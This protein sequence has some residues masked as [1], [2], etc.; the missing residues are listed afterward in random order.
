MQM[1]NPLLMISLALIS[2]AG[3]AQ[4]P[5]AIDFSPIDR[6]T[7][8]V[9]L[10]PI[11]K[12]SNYFFRMPERLTYF[13]S[14]D[15][16]T[17]EVFDPISLPIRARWH[18]AK[19]DYQFELQASGIDDIKA[20]EVR[21]VRTTVY[22]QNGVPRDKKGF[23]QD[24]TCTFYCYLLLVDKRDGKDEPLE[25]IMLSPA[26]QRETFTVHGDFLA[27]DNRASYLKPEMPFATQK[28]LADFI[29]LSKATIY[30]KAEQI[31]AARV[32]GR[33][34]LPLGVLYS[35]YK[36]DRFSYG[37]GFVKTKKRSNNYDDLDAL[38]PLYK[39]ALDSFTTLHFAAAKT[40]ADTLVGRY[41]TLLSS[42]EP[43]IDKNVQLVLL[44][45]LAHAEMLRGDIVAARAA[46]DRFI[47][48]GGATPDSPLARELAARLEFW[49]RY[50]AIKDMNTLLKK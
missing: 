17:K 50:F 41:A 22:D 27:P 46:R 18:S 8:F 48:A 32:F 34:E 43:R 9:A 2:I 20:G 23:V 19:P 13:E 24:Y 30:K 28:E 4:A 1:R 42:G 35:G 5:A 26:G 36:T 12:A 37:W 11:T 21:Y 29:L 33:A 6:K 39:T 47:A 49:Q 38:Q 25:K 15:A 16:I 3:R 7:E 45:N 10:R 44:Y 31:V 14:A 40:M